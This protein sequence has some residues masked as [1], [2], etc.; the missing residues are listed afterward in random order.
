[1][2][3]TARTPNSAIAANRPASL[4]RDA[5]I[6][7]GASLLLTL[8]AKVEVPF[9]PVPMTM[10]TAVVV[11]LGLVFGWQ[12]ALAA[13]LYYLAQ[14]AA[15]L[16]DVEGEVR[17]VEAAVDDDAVAG[18]QAVIQLRGGQQDRLAHRLVP[19]WK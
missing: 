6:V 8:S 7:I 16:H 10:Q 4:W 2:Q 1:M 19:A 3:H 18:L 17:Q 14:G 12:R 13:V 9:Y 5:L 15:G 11:G